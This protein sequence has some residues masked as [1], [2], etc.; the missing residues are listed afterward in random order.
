MYMILDK[1]TNTL[2]CHCPICA[3]KLAALLSN[4]ISVTIHEHPR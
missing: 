1:T 3:A 2:K 4:I